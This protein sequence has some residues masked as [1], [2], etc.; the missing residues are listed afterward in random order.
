MVLSVGRFA[1]FGPGHVPEFPTDSACGRRETPQF[2]RARCSAIVGKSQSARQKREGDKLGRIHVTLN[3]ILLKGPPPYWPAITRRN[4]RAG[5]DGVE[6]RAFRLFGAGNVPKRHVDSVCRRVPKRHTGFAAR[7]GCWTA[8]GNRKGTQVCAKAIQ[9]PMRGS[10]VTDAVPIRCFHS[11]RPAEMR[12]QT[13]V[14][15]EVVPIRRFNGGLSGANMRN[16]CIVVLRVAARGQVR[17]IY[18]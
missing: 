9:Y 7:R 8:Q 17:R 6:C 4:C 13:P 14:I 10:A 16:N 3:H 12:R 15:T 2:H 5:N 18:G 1:G 11:N